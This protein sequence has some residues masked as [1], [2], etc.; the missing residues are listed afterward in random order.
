MTPTDIPY[1]DTSNA[2]LPTRRTLRRRRSL[3]RQAIGFVGFN[4]RIL[5]VIRRTAATEKAHRRD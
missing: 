2:P 5:R 3:L 1:L 4:L